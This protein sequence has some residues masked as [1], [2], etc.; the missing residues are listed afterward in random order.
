MV[1]Q[2]DD[3]LNAL[4]QK[5][6]NGRVKIITG[7]RR[8]GKSYLLFHLYKDHLMANGVPADQIIEL[9]LDDIENIRYRNPFH[10]HA[11]VKERITDPDA[12]NPDPVPQG[13]QE[14]GHLAVGVQDGDP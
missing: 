4:I 8:C 3:Y 6:D 12:L 14:S 5:K 2:R 11:Y 1:I 10:L 9:Q 13:A 7:I